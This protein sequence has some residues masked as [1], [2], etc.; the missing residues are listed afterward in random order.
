MS[1]EQTSNR[2]R[3]NPL[4]PL[5][6]RADCAD[7]YCAP[8]ENG[9]IAFRGPLTVIHA[10]EEASERAGRTF[11]AQLRY[12]IEVCRGEEPVAADDDRTVDAWQS[13]VGQLEMCF[14]EGDEWI[15]CAAMFGNPCASRY[16]A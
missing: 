16:E 11:N 5:K 7:F 8:E 9:R 12:V 2:Y 3:P 6:H 14:D 13:L 10:L 15:P 4:R 1:H